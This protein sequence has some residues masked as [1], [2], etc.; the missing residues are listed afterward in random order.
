MRRFPLY[1]E[2]MGNGRIKREE[3]TI[4]AMIWLYCKASHQ[5]NGLCSECE[6]LLNYAL[7]QLHR[8]PYKEEKPTC[9]YCPVHCYK[10]EPREKIRIVM[11]Y[12]GPRLLFRHPVLAVMH[13]RDSRKAKREQEKKSNP[14]ETG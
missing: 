6:Q 10:P 13:L 1:N 11:R 7:E 9:E 5:S 2:N 14:P 3:K 8:C 12:S 4:A